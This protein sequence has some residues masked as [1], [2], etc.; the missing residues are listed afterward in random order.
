MNF[1]E[2]KGERSRTYVFADG[3]LTITNV[4]R[5]HVRPTGTHRIETAAGEKLIVRCGWH[6]IKIDCD[7]WSF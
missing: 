2:V 3:E 5:L 4:V 6:A 1:Q 7:E